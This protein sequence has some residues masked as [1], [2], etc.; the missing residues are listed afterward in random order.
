MVERARAPG[1]DDIG[2]LDETIA[3]VRELIELPLLHPHIYHH[4]G[5]AAPRGIIFHG[6]PGTGKTYLAR[7][8]ANML[9]ARYVYVDGPALV[10]SYHGETEGNLRRLFNEAAQD[11]PAI[12]LFDEIDAVIPKRDQ[13]G[14]FSD[15]RMVN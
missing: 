10:G 3:L 5:I 2:G 12:I 15:T 13:A 4:L 8:M 14:T 1:F 6:P 11:A 9:R 7:A